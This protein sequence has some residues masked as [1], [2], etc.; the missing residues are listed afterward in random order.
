MKIAFFTH[1]GDWKYG[2]NRSLINLIDG[3]QEYDVEALV[4]SPKQ[5]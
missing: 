2:S 1:Y 3:L 4:V 5:G